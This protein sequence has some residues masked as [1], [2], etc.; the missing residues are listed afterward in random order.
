ELEPTRQRLL[1][2]LAGL[3]DAVMRR[4]VR[5]GRYA[6]FTREWENLGHAV[7]LAIAAGDPR[8]VPLAAA[9]AMSWR[10]RGFVAESRDL[11]TTLLRFRGP[12]GEPDQPDGTFAGVPDAHRSAAL[13]ELAWLR[14]N[15]EEYALAEPL[16]EESLAI[17]R[18]RR[19]PLNLAEALS[20]MG[21][22][23]EY[24]GDVP[25]AVPYLREAL[26][27]AEMLGEPEMPALHRHNLA[28]TLVQVGELA[29]ATAALEQVVAGCRT[30]GPVWLLVS[31][32]HSL[33][34]TA[35]VRGDLGTALDCFTDALA[36]DRD[37]P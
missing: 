32:L 10:S 14:I 27:G 3:V 37:D 15:H 18:T 17:E 23:R 36:G 8:Q 29:E 1:A 6:V 11:L 34:E 22:C 26:A 9:F 12:A 25:A 2:Y 19:D 4:L 28:H 30:G 16:L 31:A 21:L 13:S 20:M 5:A 24:T 35:L 7:D 33:G